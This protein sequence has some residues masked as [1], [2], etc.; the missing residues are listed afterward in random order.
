MPPLLPQIETQD[1]VIIVEGVKDITT[2]DTV[3]VKPARCALRVEARSLRPKIRERQKIH[4]LEGMQ[5]R[6]V[7]KN[8]Q[9]QVRA[10]KLT[11]FAVCVKNFKVKI[12]IAESLPDSKR[13][14]FLNRAIQS[15]CPAGKKAGDF[16]LSVLQ[17][18]RRTQLSPNTIVSCL[19]AANVPLPDLGTPQGLELVRQLNDMAK[20][21][22]KMIRRMDRLYRILAA[23]V[24]TNSTGVPS[25]QDKGIRMLYR[26]IWENALRSRK[27]DQP[28]EILTVITLNT[29]GKRFSNPHMHFYLKRILNNRAHTI[30]QIDNLVR[31]SSGRRRSTIVGAPVLDCIPRELLST[32]ITSL[33]RYLIKEVDHRNERQRFRHF[34][35][36]LRVLRVLDARVAT[37][38]ENV[39]TLDLA[40]KSLAADGVHL[41]VVGRYLMYLPPELL[42]KALLH[43]LPYQESM[44]GIEPKQKEEF[45]TLYRIYL[46]TNGKLL[47]SRNEMLARLLAR[48]QQHGLPNHEMANLV[49]KLIYR[50]KGIRSVLDMLRRLKRKGVGLSDTEFLYEFLG[51]LERGARVAQASTSLYGHD[52]AFTLHASQSIRRLE[53]DENVTDRKLDKKLVS[54][55]SRR[56][57]KHIIQGARNARLLPLAYRKVNVDTLMSIRADIIHQIAYQYSLERSRTSQ[58]NWRSIYYLYK[59]LHDNELPVGPLFTNAVMRVCITQPLSEKRFVSARRLTWVCQMIAPVEGVEVAKK[60]EH[61]FGVWRGDLIQHA[62]RTL[63]ASGGM[64]KAHVSTMKKLGLL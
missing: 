20:N 28:F 63:Y 15:C 6:G 18:L 30:D 50:H 54:W 10:E 53:L 57:F 41:L 17:H 49:I 31:S 59:Y 33:P 14:D 43:W 21:S 16:T 40:V 51:K 13:F 1:G 29:L 3:A 8:T 19:V 55:Q 32:A 61:I 2:S 60:I 12:K 58:Q 11:D 46:R 38:P 5:E 36:W 47:V 23:T 42:V 4:T 56:Q 44:H 35:S 7:E 34:E 25:V 62:K 9:V 24:T 52:D 27:D 37:A 22:A 48:M 64:G 26:A 39:T 45:A